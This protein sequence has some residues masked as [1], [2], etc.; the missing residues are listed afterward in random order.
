LLV[1]GRRTGAH[2]EDCKITNH[3]LKNYKLLTV[4]KLMA[5]GDSYIRDVL[6]HSIS[7]NLVVSTF[8]IYI[9]YI[10]FG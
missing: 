5:E 7:M 1:L 6:P 8:D 10:G 3:S 9:Y 2:R 4:E